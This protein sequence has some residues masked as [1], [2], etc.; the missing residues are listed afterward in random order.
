[1]PLETRASWF[2]SKCVEAQQLTR[3]LWGSRSA[4]ETMG[5]KLHRRKGNSSDHQLRPLNDRLVINEVGVQRQPGGAA[6]SLPEERLVVGPA[7]SLP[8][9]LALELCPP[10][11]HVAQ[12]HFKPRPTDVIVATSP[13]CGT[14]WLRALVFSIVNRHSFDFSDHPLSKKNPQELVFF[15]EGAIYIDGS[16]SF[17]DGLPSPRLLSTHL[18]YSLFP[19][20]MTDDTSECRFVYICRD[21]KDVFISKWHFANKLRAKDLPPIA[22]EEAFDSFCQ[23]VS[24]YGPFWDHV[25][26][27]LESQ[28]ESPKKVLFLKY[29]DV[30]KQPWD[31]V[32][33]VAEFLEVPFSPEEENKGIVE[34]IVKLC[35]FENMSNQEVNKMPPETRNDLLAIQISSGKVKLEIGLIISHL[36]WPEALDQITEQKLQATGFNFR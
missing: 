23:G 21:P 12:H 24:H 6:H 32:R 10:R 33:K 11:K 18:P 4:S 2:S 25:L 31:C 28:L 30:K 29:E 3:H 22:L 34:G 5:D 7:F 17:I 19:T 16:T 15:L 26:G 14:T 27:L 1:M 9:L 36:K 20:S 8:R 35:S 13:K